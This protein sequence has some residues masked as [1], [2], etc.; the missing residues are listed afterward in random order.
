[1]CV[2]QAQG[3]G[4]VLGFLSDNE[5]LKP[6]TP[7]ES[8]HSKL[9]HFTFLISICVNCYYKYNNRLQINPRF[10]FWFFFFYTW[11]NEKNPHLSRFEMRVLTWKRD[12]PNH[13]ANVLGLRSLDCGG[14]MKNIHINIWTRYEL[15][16]GE[17]LNEINQSTH[18]FQLGSRIKFEDVALL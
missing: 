12:R 18:T 11:E 1:M 6:Y 4:A 3:Q 17:T 14:N 15:T 7:R 10:W 5:S 9:L 16:F 13:P 2:T 8:Y